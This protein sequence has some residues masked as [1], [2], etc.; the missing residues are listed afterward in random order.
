MKRRKR[1]STYPLLI[2]VGLILAWYAVGIAAYLVQ[3]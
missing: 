1:H 3:P 2:T